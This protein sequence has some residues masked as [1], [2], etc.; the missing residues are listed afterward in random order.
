MVCSWAK[1][2]MMSGWANPSPSYI[3]LQMYAK[4]KDQDLWGAPDL[5]SF[6]AVCA[7]H[8]AECEEDLG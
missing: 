5:T 2:P 7:C 3:G 8:C 4:K 6:E 1:W